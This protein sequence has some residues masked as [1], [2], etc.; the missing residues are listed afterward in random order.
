[1]QSKILHPNCEIIHA[2]PETNFIQ[3]E[4]IH[5]SLLCCESINVTHQQSEH[6]EREK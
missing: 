3:Q 4:I 2:R 5:V 6:F 1:M